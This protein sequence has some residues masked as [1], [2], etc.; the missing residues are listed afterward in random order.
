VSYAQF[1]KYT[2]IG[3]LGTGGMA[4]VFKC[5]LAGM[6]GFEKT[7]AIK[8]ILPERINDPEFMKMFLDEARV[9]ANL[10][11]PNISQVFEVGD[12]EGVPY[13][14]MEFVGGPTLF[15]LCRAARKKEQLHIGHIT[16]VIAG[17]CEG[18]EYAHNAKSP[19]GESLCL[20]HRDV[21]PQ[22]V[23]VSTD[24]VP[25][26]L[27]FGVAK[28]IGRL[29]LTHA[30]TIKGKIKYMAPEHLQSDVEIDGRSDVFSVGVCLFEALTG[31]LPFGSEKD[32]DVSLL[33]GITSGSYKKP[34]DFVESFPPELEKILMW[35]INPNMLERPTAGQLAEALETFVA[36]GPYQSS[37]RAL[38]TYIAQ[39]APPPVT[40]D[41]SGLRSKG[42]TSL[43]GQ[44]RTSSVSG[45]RPGSGSRPGMDPNLDHSSVM[46]VAAKRSRNMLIGAIAAVLIAGGT[47]VALKRPMQDG[48]TMATVEV[49]EDS[50]NGDVAAKMY[51]DEA[52]KLAGQK[53]FGPALN[54]MGKARDLKVRDPALNIRL[55]RLTDSLEQQGLLFKAQ[56]MLSTNQHQLA[57]E[58]AKE[59]LDVDPE[60]APAL[61]VLAKARAAIVPPQQQV[62]AVT[63]EPAAVKET[64]SGR[65]T[66]RAKAPPAPVVATA[67]L[68]LDSEPSGIVYLNEEPIGSTPINGRVL[69]AGKYSLQV[70]RNGF[71][72]WTKT[73]EL[74]AGKD[75]SFSPKL[76]AEEKR[77]LTATDVEEDKPLPA[78]VPV[79]KAR[80]KDSDSQPASTS[81]DSK[82][83]A[84]TL[85][86][87][88]VVAGD[89][90]PDRT[91]EPAVKKEKPKPHLPV[92]YKPKS[93][94]DLIRVLKI[95]EKE[96]IGTAGVPSS[97]VNDVTENLGQ[98]IN[99]ELQEIYPTALYYVIVRE[100]A[101]GHTR[102]HAS[103]T[104]KTLHSGGALKGLN[105]LPTHNTAL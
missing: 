17:V 32:T 31:R 33:R 87:A 98:S 78:P 25:K 71:V 67:K 86:A 43:P 26:L 104:L 80:D 8:R 95:V 35:A 76:V 41:D 20:V 45:V 46:A 81:S 83:P 48:Q 42:G 62:A 23:I 14:A 57:I 21:S 79:A 89:K 74:V 65:N 10:N 55:A 105:W 63:P 102:A 99:K 51:M 60:N 56:R 88:T 1:G 100:F 82:P 69:K 58:A 36:S 7:V 39:V 94:E 66:P 6:G 44:R 52:E 64:R 11:H 27:D 96:A 59:V 9:A 13:I 101:S 4:E 75:V 28:A 61:E 19:D 84:P 15:T 72:P 93:A 18:L 49:Q 34:S 12:V 29:A 90:P 68:S 16:K 2:L 30:G 73:F 22:N 50:V 37:K 70:R 24:G 54:L 38:A 47:F 3:R 103:E 97:F 85:A 40:P 92:A 91:E 53:R 77:R 5:R